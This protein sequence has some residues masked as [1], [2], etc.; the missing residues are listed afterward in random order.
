MRTSILLAVLLAVA[1]GCATTPPPVPVS[2][3]GA[4]GEIVNF[5]PGVIPGV[6][7]KMPVNVGIGEP[8][9]K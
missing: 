7:G 8:C 5:P 3:C 6:V 2:T 4:G 1:A 9:S